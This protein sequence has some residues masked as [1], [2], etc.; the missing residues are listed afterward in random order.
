MH[1]ACLGILP[2]SGNALSH[3]LDRITDR[4][5]VHNRSLDTFRNPP[6]DATRSVPSWQATFKFGI[7]AGAAWR[8]V[9][10]QTADRDTWASTLPLID[11]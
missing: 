2:L 4:E 3:R 1:D 9:K 11:L 7:E 6:T 5:G 10:R 8:W